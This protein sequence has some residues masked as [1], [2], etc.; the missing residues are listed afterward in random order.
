MRIAAILI[1]LVLMLPNFEC[2]TTSKVSDTNASASLNPLDSAMGILARPL[3]ESVK[4]QKDVKNVGIFLFK[5]RPP[6]KGYS[7]MSRQVTEAFE[8]VAY[9][10]KQFHWIERSRLAELIALQEKEFVDP[11]ISEGEKPPLDSIHGVDAYIVGS[12]FLDAD[13]PYETGR[14]LISATVWLSTGGRKLELEKVYVPLTAFPKEAVKEE[15][16]KI[17]LLRYEDYHLI[18]ER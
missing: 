6:K 12:Y 14:V 18:N 1:L 2:A 9:K 5:S 4:Q 17:P 8:Q 16:N 13:V 11:Y 15:Q 10:E 7:E 3:L